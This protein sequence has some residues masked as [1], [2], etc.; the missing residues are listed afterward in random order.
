MEYLHTNFVQKLNDEA[1]ATI[2]GEGERAREEQ[3]R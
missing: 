2:G 1:A 3:G